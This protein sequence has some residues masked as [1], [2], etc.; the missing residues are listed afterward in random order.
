MAAEAATAA[1]RPVRGRVTG[2]AE[3]SKQRHDGQS[4]DADACDASRDVSA[5]HD[6]GLDDVANAAATLRGLR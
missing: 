5:P 3:L 6:A 1:R 2:V 4:S